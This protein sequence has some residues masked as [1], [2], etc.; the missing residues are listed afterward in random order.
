MFRASLRFISLSLLVFRFQTT[1]RSPIMC[2]F[3]NH[4][5]CIEPIVCA[6]RYFPL[7]EAQARAGPYVPIPASASENASDSVRLTWPVGSA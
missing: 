2:P 3:V 6:D 4:F 7:A 1:Q 5:V